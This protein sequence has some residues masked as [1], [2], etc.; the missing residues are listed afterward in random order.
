MFEGSELGGEDTGSELFC[1]PAGRGGGVVQL[2]GKAGGGEA[3]DVE[4][5]LEA[6][7]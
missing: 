4:W 2:V 3:M 5:S 7:R 6:G 1:G